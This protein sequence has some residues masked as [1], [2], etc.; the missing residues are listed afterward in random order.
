MKIPP[1]HFYIQHL[2]EPCIEKQT[3][4]LN[5]TSEIGKSRKFLHKTLE[6]LSL[7]LCRRPLVPL[8][9]T[10]L[11]GER[12]LN[13]NIKNEKVYTSDTENSPILLL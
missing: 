1:V 10:F 3:V 9:T 5:Q 7:E 12:L 4:F 6:D 8:K 13:K 2:E 11:S